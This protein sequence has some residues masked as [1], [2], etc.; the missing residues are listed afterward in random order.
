M[1]PFEI[2]PT[3]LGFTLLE[4]VVAIVVLGLIFAGFTSVYGTVLRRG[5]EPQL[6]TQAVAFA[7]AYLDEVLG[8][9]YRDPDTGL[10]CGTQEPDRPSFD[11][12][13]DYDQLSLN[14]CTST[15]GACPVVGDCVCDRN[16]APVDGSRA[17]AVTVDVNPVNVAGASGL[18]VQLQ[19]DH[20]GLAGSGVRLQAFR[21]E[22]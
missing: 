19:V 5:A 14:G 7:A 2:R 18:Q 16:G 3:E 13:C 1:R 6:Q 20:H 15:S 11:N 4:L 22:D 8:R 17:F 9:P 21:A 12:V 10:I